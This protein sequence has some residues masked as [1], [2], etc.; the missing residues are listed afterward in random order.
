MD[1]SASC[2]LCWH[3]PPVRKKHRQSHKTRKQ[4]KPKLSRQ[5]NPKVHR[6]LIQLES[7]LTEV[8]K[9]NQKSQSTELS[10][11]TQPSNLTQKSKLVQQSQLMKQSKPTS[12]KT[13]SPKPTQQLQPTKL[14]NQNQTS[15]QPLSPMSSSAKSTGPEANSHKPMNG[16]RS[17]IQMARLWILAGGFSTDEPPLEMR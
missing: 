1:S 11:P 6:Q 12:Q 5:T 8:S 17:R 9:H 14:L 2:F 10:K 16:L 3:Y 7:M 4:N 15:R 13:Q